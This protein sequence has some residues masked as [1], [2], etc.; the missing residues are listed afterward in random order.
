MSCDFVKP[1]FTLEVGP[2][3]RSSALVRS[4]LQGSPAVFVRRDATAQERHNSRPPHTPGR[5]SRCDAPERG[6][7]S[8]E[9]EGASGDRAKACWLTPSQ[10]PSLD[11][12][13]ALNL[14]GSGLSD[15]SLL[16]RL[17]NVQVLSLS[18]NRRYC[19]LGGA[20][21]LGSHRRPES[22]RWSL[23]PACCACASC[24]CEKTRWPTS[25]SCAISRIFPISGRA[26]CGEGETGCK[27]AYPFTP[28]TP[29]PRSPLASR[30]RLAPLP[31]PGAVAVRLPVRGCAAVPCHGRR[32]P[33]AG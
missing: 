31:A 11:T 28:A 14:W 23:S 12:V 16:S 27:P 2:R 13:Q 5:T 15:V 24:T 7:R 10:S 25:V 19:L 17:T 4:R 32:P 3:Y 6:D 18:V 1:G 33:P 8:A 26:E 30:A 20:G 22:R 29:S 9:D 21:C